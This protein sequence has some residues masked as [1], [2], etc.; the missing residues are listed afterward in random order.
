MPYF[1]LDISV[2]TIRPYAIYVSP[3]HLYER[4][5]TLISTFKKKI[6]LHTRLHTYFSFF[7]D[8]ETTGL[9]RISELVQLAAIEVNWNTSNHPIPLQKSQIFNQF[10]LP[11]QKIDFCSS[12]ITGIQ[13][14]NNHLFRQNL[15]SG[16]YELQ[17]SQSRTVVLENFFYDFLKIHELS[18]QNQL[19]LI[20]FNSQR[21]DN[22]RLIYNFGPE[23]SIHDDFFKHISFFDVYQEIPKTKGV[24]NNLSTVYARVIDDLDI[25]ATNQFVDDESLRLH[26]GLDDCKAT[27]VILKHNFTRDDVVAKRTSFQEYYVKKLEEQ[28]VAENKVKTTKKTASKK[29]KKEKRKKNK[30]VS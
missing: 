5:L 29:V 28:K 27:Q 1:I 20:G 4:S 24:K 10:I 30:S 26:D 19:I 13:K 14:F 12:K 17:P 7:H 8:L 15:Q 9:K 16:K 22:Y 3:Y 11:N 6:Q 21:F 25:T 2:C 18:S 23:F